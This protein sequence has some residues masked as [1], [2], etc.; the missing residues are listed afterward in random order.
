MLAAMARGARTQYANRVDLM[1]AGTWVVPAGVTSVNV[2]AATRGGTAASLAAWGYGAAAGGGGGAIYD[3]ALTVVPGNTLTLTPVLYST[4]KQFQIEDATAITL[5]FTIETGWNAP[6]GGVLSGGNG[7]QVEWLQGGITTA[8]RGA[9]SS[10]AGGNGGNGQRVTVAGGSIL[11]GGGGGAPGLLVP[12]G[13][14]GNGGASDT[15]A[16]ISG[17]QPNGGAGGGLIPGQYALAN[18]FTY[19]PSGFSS[20]GFCFLEYN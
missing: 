15:F 7:A 4:F 18:S 12:Q 19:V 17:N 13:T 11:S 14:G 8:T 16:G 10:G 5:L 1:S 2:F 3:C 9:A 20:D 6:G